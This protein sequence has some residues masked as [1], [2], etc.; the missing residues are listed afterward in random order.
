[1]T[2]E[3]FTFWLKGFTEGKTSLSELE[4]KIINDKINSIVNPPFFNDQTIIQP[5]RSPLNDDFWY[6]PYQVFCSSLN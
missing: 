3:Q 5:Y 2:H 6:Q 1:M 4:I